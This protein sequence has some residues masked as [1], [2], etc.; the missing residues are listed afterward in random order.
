[1]AMAKLEVFHKQLMIIL[2]EREKLMSAL[3]ELRC[4]SHI[5]PSDAN[6]ILVKFTDAKR[7]FHILLDRKIVIRDRSN[8]TGCENALRISVGTP[9]ENS[10]LIKTLQ[11]ICGD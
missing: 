5:Y 11:E 8:Q 9:D 3:S 2:A 7:V 10:E 1:M 6:F 4:I